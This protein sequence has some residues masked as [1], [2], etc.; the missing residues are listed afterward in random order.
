MAC[1]D[2]FSAQGMKKALE[3]G[4]IAQIFTQIYGSPAP[5]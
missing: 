3:G 2:R 1:V 4:E 5:D